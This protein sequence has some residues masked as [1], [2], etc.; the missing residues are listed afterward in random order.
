[1]PKI[2][3]HIARRAEISAV[4]VALIAEGGL[5]AA[6]FREIAQASGY[7]KGVVEH[8]FD[9][10]EAL[11]SATLLWINKGYEQRVKH[12]CKGLTGLAALRKRLQATL[13]IGKTIR[14]EWKV[15]LV[16]WS[17][18]ATTEDLRKV[19]ELRF[20]HAA[21]A[22]EHDIIAAI[23]QGQLHTNK[24]AATLARRL[25][26]SVAGIS[27]IALHSRTLYTKQF[28]LD[29]IDAMISQLGAN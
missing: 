22:F 7:S 23:E 21:D 9:N 19:Q 1:M 26:S 10:K 2:V 4:A 13:P 24:P 29:E 14:D 17:M 25:F 5:E 8:Y 3:D 11:I 16:F 28:M 18:A 20:N 6:T 15:R 27:V 12:A